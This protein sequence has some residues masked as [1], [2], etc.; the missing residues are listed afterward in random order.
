[1]PRSDMQTAHG[2]PSLPDRFE[3]PDALDEFLS[4][5]GEDL[6][7][8]MG[9]V[10]GDIII[11][12]ASGKMGPTLARLARNAAPGKRVVAVARFS[13][14]ESRQRMEDWGIETIQADLLDERQ[15]P[16]RVDGARTNGDRLRGGGQPVDQVDQPTGEPFHLGIIQRLRSI[17]RGVV[18]R[19]A[20]G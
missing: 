1:M 14:P 6:V 18:P 12:G 10:E 3:T 7:R 15:V 19:R 13:E 4:L 16:T 9:D 17:V 8:D 5:P 20:T 2:R 11:L